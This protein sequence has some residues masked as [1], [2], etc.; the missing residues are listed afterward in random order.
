MI[1]VLI[2]DD[3]MA[4]RKAMRTLLERADDI[5]VI[6]EAADGQ[7][8]VD[9]VKQSVPDIIVMDVSM[10]RMDGIEAAGKIVTFNP[11]IRILMVSV[12]KDPYMVKRA[13]GTGA[14][15]YVIK[16]V[17]YD[18]LTKAIRRIWAGEIYLCPQIAVLLREEE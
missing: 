16:D 7:E 8:A 14:K 11:N 12:Y 6:G 2:V 9:Y 4:V 1:Q 3:F 15:G 5:E 18:Q 17:I 13:L 10:P